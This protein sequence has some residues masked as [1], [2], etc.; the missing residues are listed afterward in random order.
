[1]TFSTA[2]SF[3]N[4]VKIN[5][6]FKQSVCL[7]GRNLH[8]SWRDYNMLIFPLHNKECRLHADTLYC[9]KVWSYPAACY[10]FVA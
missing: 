6:C 7:L 2:V 3:P 5:T 9:F 8:N 1:M 10:T 4:V